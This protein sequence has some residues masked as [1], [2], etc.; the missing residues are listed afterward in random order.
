MTVEDGVITVAGRRLET[1]RWGPRDGPCLVLLHEGLGSV[2]LWRDF[3]ERLAERTGFSVFAWSRAG[4]GHS[5][6]VPLPRPIDYMTREAREVV[7]Q[8]LDALGADRVVL[9]GHSDGASIAAIHA[10]RGTAPRLRGLCLIA[11][12]FFTEPEGL[13]AIRAARMAYD[14]GD[15]RARLARHHGD[16]DNAFRGW[17]DAWLAPAFVHWNI[18]DAIDG[19]TCPVLAIQGLDDQYGTLAQLDALDRR[20]PQPPRRVELPGCRHA[21]HLENPD[22]VLDAIAGF[23]ANIAV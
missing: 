15:L 21:P 13:A 6:P 4:Y 5:D 16:P 17:N 2:G 3:P 19:I 22:A 9:I 12:H 10:G 7:P 14:R 18:E 20:L 23:L 8:V 11:P 1:R